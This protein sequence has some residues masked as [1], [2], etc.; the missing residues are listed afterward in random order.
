MIRKKT[1]RA[2]VAAL[3]ALHPAS[4]VFAEEASTDTASGPVA[5]SDSTP[6]AADGTPANSERITVTAQKFKDARINLSPK[7]GTTV[8]SIEDAAID[9]IGKGAATPF[10]EVLLRLPGVDKDSKASGS[11]H[12]RDD[13]G[14]VQ[15]RVN[16]VQL[17]EAISGFGTS[18]DTRYVSK[19]DFV[20]GA[21][22]AQYGLRTAGIVEIQTREGTEQG[23][24]IGLTVGSNKDFEPSGQVFGTVGSLSYY[25][26]GSYVTNENGIEFPTPDK[27]NPH[28]KTH[29]VKS[30]GNF[31][32]YVDD[33]TRLG[34]MFGTYNGKFEIPVNPGQDPAFSLTGYSDLDT[35]FIALPSSQLDQNQT[36]A[37]R[38]FV[39]TLQ[40]SVG[41]LDYQLSLFHQYS[42]LHYKPDPQGDL[43][44]LGVASDTMRSNNANGVQLD[45]SYKLA[46]SHTVRFG[47]G[48]TQQ[49][50]QSNNSVGVFPTDADGNQSSSDPFTIID[51]SG[52]TGRLYSAY[53]QDEWRID[54]KF[55][56]NYGLRY[57]K[58][59]AFVNEQ[60]WSPRVNVAY[61][62]TQ[63]T[64]VHA[65]YSRYFTPP[66]QELAAQTSVELYA[67]TTNAPEIPVSDNVKS[68]RTNYYDIG[69]VHKASPELTL[70]A[71]A[72]YKD[73]KNLIDEGQ[74]GAALILSPFNYERGH[75]QGLELSAVYAGTQWSAYANLAYQKAQGKHIISG[76]ALFG[77]D[78]LAYIADHYIY[79]DHD[80]TYTA[81]VGA[82]YKFGANRVNA[83]AL[84]G[85]GL[86][87][88]GDNDIP[89]GEALPDYTVVNASYVHTWPTAYGQLD[90]RLGVLNLFDKS[91]ELRDG[92][93]VGVGAPQW[94][95]RRTFFGSLSLSF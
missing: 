73:I 19:I 84:Y 57:D 52:K 35:G 43:I 50:T 93:G 87:R 10:D 31:S 70:T 82:S 22:P 16:G 37:N 69:V 11:L 39:A 63:D 61:Q 34:F 67:N 23:G 56:V 36:E 76:Q 8:Y 85:S 38:F 91:Y 49:K 17:P 74:F 47:G 20:T 79:L 30:F 1:I 89:N 90:G 2:A 4:A 54:P 15:Y 27:S 7:V 62:V 88:T 9:T 44:Y 75:A 86:R 5:A 71:D 58:V 80:Q 60:Q 24:Q 48:Y 55:T 53:L 33:S 6:A 77:V 18:I 40:R 65:G 14:N 46:A 59:D 95:I 92:S 94:G 13:H 45:A 66:P 32:Y 25:L 42:D 12:V 28:D 3:A 51:N 83:D 21:L 64:A 29:Q 72:Y 81:S 41:A 78:E 26:S 68:E